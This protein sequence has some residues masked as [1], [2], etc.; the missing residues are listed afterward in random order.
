[1]SIFEYQIIKQIEDLNVI[2]IPNGDHYL[3]GEDNFKFF[4]DIPKNYLV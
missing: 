3:S 1:M 2:V 4:L